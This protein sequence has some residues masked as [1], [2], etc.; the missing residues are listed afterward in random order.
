M[1][2]AGQDGAGLLIKE[3]GILWGQFDLGWLDDVGGTWLSH[4]VNFSSRRAPLL[5]FLSGVTGP[6]CFGF[7]MDH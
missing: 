7:M 5:V 1:D 3:L 4:V 6:H 2:M